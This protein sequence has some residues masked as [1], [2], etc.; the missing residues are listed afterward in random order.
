MGD[1]LSLAAV[2]GIG[3]LVIQLCGLANLLLGA[4]VGRWGSGVLPL[5]IGYS[6]AVLPQLL[7]CCA[8]AVVA[9]LLR[10]ILLIES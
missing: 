6:L 9:W 7:L 10:R 8:V 4:M 2:A 3:L 1:P 5:V